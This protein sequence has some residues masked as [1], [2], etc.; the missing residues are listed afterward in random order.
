MSGAW[1]GVPLNPERSRPHWLVVSD[2]KSPVI[3]DWF[4]VMTGKITNVW[5]YQG[6]LYSP[7]QMAKHFTYGEPVAYPDD[8]AAAVQAE[9]EGA[10]DEAA[11]LIIDGLAKMLGVAEFTPCDGTETWDGDVLGTVHRILV[12][13]RIIDDEDG[14]IARHG[15]DAALQAA[16]REGMEAAADCQ[17][18]TA[19]NPNESE[20]HRGFFDGVMVYSKRIRARIEEAKGEGS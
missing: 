4:A 17:P 16:R 2:A 14:S 9:R 1:D 10:Q 6:S 3:A 13:G 15:D 20:Y 12:A 7:A 18:C 8:H 5:R 11:D 19:E